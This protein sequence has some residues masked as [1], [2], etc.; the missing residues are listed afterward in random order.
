MRFCVKA[1]APHDLRWREEILG[2]A[3][4]L[5]NERIAT[6]CAHSQITLPSLRAGLDG[7]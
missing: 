2:N 6:G 3:V 7:R 4:C 1:V 5:R